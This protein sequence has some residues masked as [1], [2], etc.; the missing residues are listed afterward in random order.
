LDDVWDFLELR[1]AAGQPATL[2]TVVQHEGSAPG[3]R[4]FKMAV[5]ADGAWRGTIGGGAMELRLLAKA[6]AMAGAGAAPELLAQVH[7]ENAPASERSGM[8]CAGLQKIALIPLRVEALSTIRRIREAT[9]GNLVLSGRGLSIDD[10]DN[11]PGFEDGAD[12]VYRESL[13]RRDR[14][15]VIGSG[16]VGLA[17]CRVLATLD[18]RVIAFDHRPEA[19]TFVQNHYAHEKH[20][21]PYEELAD[22]V[23]EG[24]D[25]YAAV[26]TTAF[27]TDVAALR[28]LIGKRLRYLGLMGSTAKIKRIFAELAKAG[29][30][31]ALY[32]KVHA[33]LGLPIHN[34]TPAEIA[35]SAA[36]EIVKVRNAP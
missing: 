6:Q 15:Y 16:H 36:A 33:P 20:A 17:I 4:G 35:I 31:P 34:R 25:V 11:A 29:V 32:D 7:R 30:D 18:L 1:L 14:V 21:G 19:A 10:G 28:Q 22:L 5:A 26:V 8:I 23:P 3:K 27:H 12:W 2:M 13:G 24:N 9:A